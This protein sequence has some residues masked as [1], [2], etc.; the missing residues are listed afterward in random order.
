MK[1]IGTYIERDLASSKCRVDDFDDLSCQEN[2]SDAD[3]ILTGRFQERFIQRR[4]SE[5]SVEA[6]SGACH[7]SPA[8]RLTR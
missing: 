2:N 1:V 4:A 3:V 6:C 5:G 7:R 8:R